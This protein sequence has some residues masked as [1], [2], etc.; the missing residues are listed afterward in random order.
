MASTHYPVAVLKKKQPSTYH[1]GSV[2]NI[3]AHTS[4]KKGLQRNHGVRVTILGCFSGTTI[5]GNTYMIPTSQ[6]NMKLLHLFPAVSPEV[7]LE[8]WVPW[9]LDKRAQIH[10]HHGQSIHQ[11]SPTFG[12]IFTRKLDVSENRGFSLQI[13]HFNRGFHYKPSILGYPIFGNT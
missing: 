9:L 6:N 11:I 2:C 8:F 13:I 7:I 3:V 12:L 1:L 10:L 5:L 4:L